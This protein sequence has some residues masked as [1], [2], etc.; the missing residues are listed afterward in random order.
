MHRLTSLPAIMTQPFRLSQYRLMKMYD[1]GG[2]GA[3][4]VGGAAGVG[5][6]V[7]V[8]VNRGSVSASLGNYVQ[9]G[10]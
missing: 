3:A 1:T 10:K 4:A 8:T 2:A 6:G 9:L 5:I 7:A